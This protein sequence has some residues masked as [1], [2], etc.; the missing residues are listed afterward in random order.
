MK[1]HAIRN[2]TMRIHYHG[3][4]IV[5]DP[6]LADKFS[7]P[8]YSGK[9]TNPL[10]DLPI[11]AEDVINGADFFL[12][13]HL[14]SDHFDPAAMELLSRESPIFCQPDDV[15]TLKREGF[16]C[17]TPVND[18]AERNGIRLT[19][20]SGQHGSGTVLEEMG[21]ASG[22]VISARGEPTILWIGDSLL[23]D[24]IRAEIKRAKPDVIITHSCGAVWGTQRV[25]ILTD[26]I[27]TTEICKLAPNSK[28]IAVHMEALDHATISRADLQAYA[29]ANAISDD[30]LLIPADGEM[31]EL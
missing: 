10:V 19:R 8:S 16:K 18:Q 1:L 4:L 3:Q 2:A 11:P 27:Q 21:H 30:Q 15:N 9:S 12:L 23:T 31:I 22:F 13:S 26:A 24:T 17:V 6:Y 14:H 28:V 5:C 7:R 25:L 20:F 29:R